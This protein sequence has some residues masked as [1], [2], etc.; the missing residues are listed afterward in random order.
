MVH[1]RRS[2]NGKR[3]LGLIVFIIIFVT[4]A[5]LNFHSPTKNQILLKYE[6]RMINT[7]A[8]MHFE[9][10]V[11]LFLLAMAINALLIDEY[12]MNVM[13]IQGPLCQL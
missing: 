4:V 10:A 11:E 1:C 2:I 6:S 9:V 3:Y 8:E 5:V 7:S 13:S 12:R